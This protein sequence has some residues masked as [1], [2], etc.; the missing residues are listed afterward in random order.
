MGLAFDYC[1]GW[2]AEGAAQ[3]GFEAV[4]V[5]D[6]TRSVGFPPDSVEKMR[7]SF[8]RN[9]IAVIHSSHRL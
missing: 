8:A 2:S 3:Q 9:N 4:V 1:V 7:A 5:E 6:A